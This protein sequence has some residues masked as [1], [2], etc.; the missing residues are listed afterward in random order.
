M[1]DALKS[2]SKCAIIA[3]IAAVAVAW[4]LVTQ[5][6]E[7]AE[8]DVNS[9]RAEIAGLRAE[10]RENQIELRRELRAIRREIHHTNGNDE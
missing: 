4:I 2:G 6:Q 1:L 3:F 8:S 5:A 10:M 9:L 7:E